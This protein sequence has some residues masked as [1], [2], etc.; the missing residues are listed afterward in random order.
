MKG[1]TGIGEIKG[2]YWGTNKVTK[3]IFE[4][5]ADNDLSDAQ[6]CWDTGF[7]YSTLNEW[8]NDRK[9]PGIDMIEVFCEALKISLGEFFSGGVFSD[10]ETKHSQNVTEETGREYMRICF[11]IYD[12]RIEA[13]I[14]PQMRKYLES[15]T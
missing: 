13:G 7:N 5:L 12:R 8:R 1:D 15:H 10:N 4:L 14:L 3:R 6:F 2:N 11:A 9:K